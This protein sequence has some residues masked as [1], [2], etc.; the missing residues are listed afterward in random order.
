MVLLGS[1]LVACIRAYLDVAPGAAASPQ[2]GDVNVLGWLICRR[3]GCIAS[4]GGQDL[5]AD[6][7][8]GTHRIHRDQDP[9]GAVPRR[10]RGCHVIVQGQALGVDPRWVVGAMLQRGARDRPADQPRRSLA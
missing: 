7:L 1:A 3:K 4:E 8:R 9:A 2:A 6:L 5:A 10:D